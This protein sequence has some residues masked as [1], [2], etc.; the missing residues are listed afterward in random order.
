MRISQRRYI[1]KTE[2]CWEEAFPLPSIVGKALLL[3]TQKRS[4][5]PCLKSL[6]ISKGPLPSPRQR[7]NIYMF[8][9]ALLIDHWERTDLDLRTSVRWLTAPVV[10]RRVAFVMPR[11]YLS[12]HQSTTFYANTLEAAYTW[13]HY[14]GLPSVAA[15]GL[16]FCTEEEDTP[17][18]IVT[19]RVA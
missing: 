7:K 11:Q 10:R 9:D 16:S 18:K 8:Q 2:N 13:Y 12:H 1:T 15:S 4:L 19:Q 17:A 3:S 5:A 6:S 14:I